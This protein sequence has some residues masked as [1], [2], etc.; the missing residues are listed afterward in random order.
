MYGS[1]GKLSSCKA[2]NE[3][4]SDIIYILFCDNIILFVMMC[5]HESYIVTVFE[6]DGVYDS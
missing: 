4:M 6:Y 5:A 1:C 2:V 3:K